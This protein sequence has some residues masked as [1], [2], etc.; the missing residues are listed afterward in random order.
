MVRPIHGQFVTKGMTG[1]TN[2]ITQ[3]KSVLGEEEG[4]SERRGI[5]AV[6]CMCFKKGNEVI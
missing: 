4:E 6:I 1:Q 5:I 2:F 3:K